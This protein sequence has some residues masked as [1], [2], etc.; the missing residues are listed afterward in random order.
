MQ[1]LFQLQTINQLGCNI[2]CKTL[3]RNSLN[4]IYR[5]RFL[6]LWLSLYAFS[7]V[8]AIIWQFKTKKRQMCRFK[9]CD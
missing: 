1:A 3:K 5:K 6:L 8:A 4:L 9:S 2:H 7:Y